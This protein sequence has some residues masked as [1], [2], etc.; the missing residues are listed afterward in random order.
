MTLLCAGMSIPA[1]LPLW[2]AL[3]QGWGQWVTGPERCCPCHL[4]QV[5]TSAA[6]PC[7]GLLLGS[8]GKNKPLQHKVFLLLQDRGSC[9]A[10]ALSWLRSG[11]LWV[12]V[13]CQ[14]P[15]H[16]GVCSAEITRHGWALQQGRCVC[17]GKR[18]KSKALQVSVDV[19][20]VSRT[21]GRVLVASSALQSLGQ[22]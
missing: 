13:L 1:L 4:T 2:V 18:G 10:S 5:S 12:S 15:L 22:G 21:E 8:L 16:P 7:W 19:L 14:C 9:C 20:L 6:P 3:G 17:L 11:A